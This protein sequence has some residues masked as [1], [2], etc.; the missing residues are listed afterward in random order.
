M[1]AQS[2]HE[3]QARRNEMFFQSLDKTVSVNREW[4]VTGSFYAALHWIEALFDHQGGLHFKEHELRNR[5]VRRLSLHIANEYFRLYTA[6]R[7]GRYE[8][9]RFSQ[10][11][12]DDQIHRNYI[13][14]RNYVLNVLHPPGITP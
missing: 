7:R 5:T 9:Y 8:L 6:S 14:I 11:E 2:Q 1:P 3:A 10:S 13:P 12:V 4:I